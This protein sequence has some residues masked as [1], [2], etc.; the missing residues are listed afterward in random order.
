MV[1]FELG[2]LPLLYTRKQYLLKLWCNL[3]FTNNIVLQNCYSEMLGQCE[4]DPNCKNWLTCVKHELDSLSLSDYWINL[5]NLNAPL[6]LATMKQHVR[7]QC[8][9]N[10]QGRIETGRKSLLYKHLVHSYEI[11]P[12]LIKPIPLEFK[13]VFVSCGSPHTVSQSRQDV[14][15]ISL[16]HNA[17]VSCM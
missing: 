9:Q 15:Q 1:F 2:Q 8:Q 13:Q 14:I 3:L 12:Y 6:F 10:L 4:V 17:S 11:Q 16:L 7:D 5:H